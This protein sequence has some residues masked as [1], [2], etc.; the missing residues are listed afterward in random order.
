[1]KI[2]QLVPALNSGGVERGTLEVARALVAA[3]H[4]SVVISSGGRMVAQLEAE[5]TRHITLPI[6]KKALSSLWQIRPLRKIILKEHADVLHVRSRIPAWLTHFAL[7]KLKG[8]ARPVLISTVHGFYSVNRYSEIMTRADRVIAV[9]DSVVEYIRDNYPA[10][11][12]DRVTRIYRGI[13]PDEFP[14]GYRP[15]TMWWQKT[16]HDFPELE[17]KFWLTLPGRITRL[18]GHESLFELIKQLKDK[19][20]VHGVVV[21]DAH[22]KKQAYLA[23]LHAKVAELGLTE[24]ITFVGHK[25][26]IREWLAAS[27]LVLSLSA[28]AETF[29]RTTLEAISVGTPVVGWDRGGV[30]EILSECYP[31]GLVAAEDQVALTATVEDLLADPVAP[32]PVTSFALSQ[33]TDQTLAV[34][35]DMVAQKKGR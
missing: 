26:D 3:G 1:M 5:G 7:R 6:H 21:G 22:E 10:C 25:S 31:E 8:A 27:D 34:Y 18:K 30:A 17:H 35:A 16:L 23:E 13:N 2:I 11:P 32:V 19:Y 15:S 20:P 24:H 12:M 33:M 28:Q 29:G 9:S 4:E 14:H